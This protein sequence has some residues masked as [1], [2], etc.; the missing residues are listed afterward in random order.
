MANSRYPKAKLYALVLHPYRSWLWRLSSLALLP[1]LATLFLP[2]AA[3][4]EVPSIALA[5]APS[6]V[7]IK[8]TPGGTGSQEIT[9]YND[10]ESAFQVTASIGQYK[11]AL[12]DNSAEKWL[13]VEP[14]LF[15][16]T[17]GQNRTVKVTISVPEGLQSG[18]RYAQVT[19]T[20]RVDSV[21][22]GVSARL[23][24]PFLITVE[25]TGPL[26]RQANISRVIPLLQD[27]GSVGF[28]VNVSNSGN[29]HIVTSGEAEV[30]DKGGTSVGI[31]DIPESTAILPSTSEMLASAGSV[32]VS[33]GDRYHARV[34]LDYGGSDSLVSDVD[35]MLSQ[36]L[37][38]EQLSIKPSP[39]GGFTIETALYNPGEV[40]VAPRLRAAVA[41]ADGKIIRTAGSLA[42]GP[43]L[44]GGR[45]TVA[46]PV[47][48]SLDKGDYTLIG[49]ADYG[50]LFST[51]QQTQFHISAEVLPINPGWGEGPAIIHKEGIAAWVWMVAGG[52]AL[53]IIATVLVLVFRRKVQ[54]AGNMR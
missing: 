16:L 17:G 41:D 18:G 13:K 19:F 50:L 23:G 39:G 6:L 44:P 26:T 35:F 7:E 49:I 9:V 5:V 38:A 52:V 29:L 42:V 27:S 46:I 43:V 3:A 31:L 34:S 22:T 36:A 28:I 48:W 32:V 10:S 24:V 14:Q 25:G 12:T 8:A 47:S 11:T 1:L 2:V 15:D 37:V 54:P 51:R 20:G 45:T 4:A 30:T 33:E 21:S 40:A 53:L